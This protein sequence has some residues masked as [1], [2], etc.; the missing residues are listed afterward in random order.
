VLISFIINFIVSL[1]LYILFDLSLNEYQFI[2]KNYN[3]AFYNLYLGVDGISI[4]FILLTTMIMPIVILSNWDSINKDIESY[5]LI[6]LVLEILLILIFM[7]L[8]TLFFYIFF[9]SILLPL[10]LLIGLFG[11]KKKI[12]ASF[13]FFL[14]TLY[15]SLFLLISILIMNSITGTT[16]FDLLFKSNFYY[17]TQVLLFCGIF[18]AFA[19]KTPTIFFNN[20]LLKAHVESPLGG[21]IILAAKTMVAL[22]LAICGEYPIL[23]LIRRKLY[24]FWISCLIY[25]YWEYIYIKFKNYYYSLNFYINNKKLNRILRDHTLEVNETITTEN[26]DNIKFSSYLAG[27]IEGDGC[28]YIAKNKNASMIVITFHSKDIPLALIIQKNLGVGNIYKIKGRNAYNYTIS[29]FKG[30]L[31][32]VNLINGYMRTPKVI[33]LYKLID[34]LKTKNN[35]ISINKLSLNNASLD[36]DAWLS[37]FIDADGCFTIRVTQ[38]KHCSTKKISVMLALVQKSINLNKD[39]LLDI[40]TKISQFLNCNLKTTIKYKYLQYSARTANLNGNIL[41]KE[42]INKY[43]LFSGKYLDFLIWEKVLTMIINKKHKKNAEVI[44]KLKANMNSKRTYFNWNH[45]N[46]FYNYKN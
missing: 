16:D 1:I 23:G 9:E 12:R 8:D 26:E 30:L 31:K 36:S 45:L 32:V 25:L 5:L 22:N 20:W 14:Y 3:I 10:F 21:S 24:A 28:I 43:P 33:Q 41:I 7:V 39:S 18:F 27:L 2:Q 19:V 4:Y 38:N 17:I 15:G 29:D 37:G 6:M 34:W 42:Y 46:N 11:S 44:I 13:Y 35:N 40:M